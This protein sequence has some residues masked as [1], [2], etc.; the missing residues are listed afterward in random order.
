MPSPPGL[1]TTV[2]VEIG[3]PVVNGSNV[4]GL[5]G[6]IDLSERVL[7]PKTLCQQLW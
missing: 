3:L 7:H 4:A 1:E 5:I 2:D 6:S